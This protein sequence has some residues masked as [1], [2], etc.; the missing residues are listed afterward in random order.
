MAAHMFVVITPGS[1]RGVMALGCA[2][3][4][5]GSWHHNNRGC[6]GAAGWLNGHPAVPGRLRGRDPNAARFCVGSPAGA[7][8]AQD[9]R[10]MA[11]GV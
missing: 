8:A 4:T 2:R 10:W 6:A 11:V 7:Q 1:K 5:R 3:R 9:G